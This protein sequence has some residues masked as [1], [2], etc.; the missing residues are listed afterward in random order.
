MKEGWKPP[1]PLC[2]KKQKFV[3]FTKIKGGPSSG[4]MPEVSSNRVGEPG[5]IISSCYLVFK[6]FVEEM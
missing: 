1:P 3:F 5:H 2:I 4:N 6:S